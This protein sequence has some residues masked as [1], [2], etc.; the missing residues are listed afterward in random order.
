MR[1]AK[2]LVW[3][4]NSTPCC[5][6]LLAI[7][8]MPL[9]RAAAFNV[10]LPTKPKVNKACVA[11]V[12]A[13]IPPSAGTAA[14]HGSAAASTLAAAASGPVVAAA[15]GP[16]ARTVVPSAATAVAR[17]TGEGE[18]FT[19][20]NF[21]ASSSGARRRKSPLGTAGVHL[22][23]GASAMK[24][25][26]TAAAVQ[27]VVV[28][29]Y[30]QIAAPKVAGASSA[31]GKRLRKV[32]VPFTQ[33]RRAQHEEAK[34]ARERAH[35]ALMAQ[36]RHNT[37]DADSAAAVLSG[38]IEP[39]TKPPA[40][41]VKQ[42][43]EPADVLGALLDNAGGYSRGGGRQR[44]QRLSDSRRIVSA[45]EGEADDE[46]V[47]LQ[48]VPGASS[49]MSRGNRSGSSGAS[50]PGVRAESN[51][52]A[53][54]SRATA[55]AVD[56]LARPSTAHA[57][58]AHQRSS[59]GSWNTRQPAAQAG[60]AGAR[61]ASVPLGDHNLT[62]AEAQRREALQRTEMVR[63]HVRA[64]R[65]QLEAKPATPQTSSQASGS[66]AGGGGSCDFAGV[67][68]AMKPGGSS[69]TSLSPEMLQQML[70][71]ESS[72]ADEGQAEVLAQARRHAEH[73]EELEAMEDK[74]KEVT[75]LQRTGWFCSLCERW[76]DKSPTM[77]FAESHDVVQQKRREW[78]FKCGHCGHKL[79]H[80]ASVC[81]KECPNC[82]HRE[83]QS[84]SIHSLRGESAKTAALVAGTSVAPVLEVRAVGE[85][86]NDV[87]T[88]GSASFAQGWGAAPPSP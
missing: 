82:S 18:S 67:A 84:T 85:H 30:T 42:E 14:P 75:S 1:A 61:S 22:S 86:A 31:T 77:C 20:I 55:S 39:G 16:A 66:H 50:I 59:G 35:K 69:G 26:A 11:R 10:E 58:A 19:K 64:N 45:A 60:S 7:T 72:H 51:S 32:D 49:S 41:R 62:F 33:A 6:A 56:P 13:T 79:F 37:S 29:G 24:P 47:E 15:P 25:I 57:A 21:I 9:C 65:L 70:A 73:L 48:L 52:K 74:M 54:G 87:V 40:K 12:P 81:A 44:E 27:P 4:R 8:H 43:D 46:A 5:A 28:A 71:A 68:T 17:S 88:D 76:F 83:W 3:L 80:R 34:L 53:I 36:Q 2:A 23:P 78:A 63:E 38:L